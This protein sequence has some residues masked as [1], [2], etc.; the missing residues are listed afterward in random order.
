MRKILAMILALSMLATMTV[1]VFADE[2]TILAELLEDN[3]I[4]TTRTVDVPVDIQM[5]AEG[6]G[7]FKDGPFSGTSNAKVDYKATIYMKPVRDTYSA[8][9]MAARLLTA[10]IG[11]LPTQLENCKIVGG[12][13]IKI[14]YPDTAEVPTVV[15]GTGSLYGFNDAAGRIFAETSRVVTDGTI[16]GTKDLTITI[17]VVGPAPDRNGYVISS[18][19]TA[20]LDAYLLVLM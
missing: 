8:Y 14:T 18:D 20:N 10:G 19:M 5:D 6:T 2:P 7:V 4:A 13:T 9:M 17:D 1:T 3:S 12:F 15:L 11:D 16:A